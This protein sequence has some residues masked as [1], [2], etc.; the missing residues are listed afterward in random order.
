M[1]KTTVWD[2]GLVPAAS[3]LAAATR[4]YLEEGTEVLGVPIQSPLYG[5]AVEA[6]LGKLG[7][8]I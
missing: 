2:P 5:S 7:C 4:L 6:H 8:E 1:R 3:S